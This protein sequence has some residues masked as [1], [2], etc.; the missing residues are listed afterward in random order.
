LNDNQLLV[1][2]SFD[3]RQ[4]RFVE[5][6]AIRFHMRLS[7]FQLGLRD[8]Q[9]PP[10]VR[11]RLLQNHS[12]MDVFGGSLVARCQRFEVFGESLQLF[13]LCNKF[14]LRTPTF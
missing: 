5:I 14:L 3:A 11:L 7:L 10:Q 6:I 9:L 8:L 13:L 2:A 12:P 4:N 1:E